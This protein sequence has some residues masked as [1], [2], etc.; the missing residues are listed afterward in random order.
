M[1]EHPDVDP[2]TPSDG[3]LGWDGLP[4]WATAEEMAFAA[5]LVELDRADR[6][7]GLFDHAGFAE[8]APW[9]EAVVSDDELVSSLVVAC[10]K[11]T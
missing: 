7:A 8:S 5:S 2:R 11:P 1:P 10:T 3:G 6:E 9:D 4:I